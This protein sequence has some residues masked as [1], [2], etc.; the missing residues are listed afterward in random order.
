[1]MFKHFVKYLSSD[2]FCK[3]LGFI[4]LP[5][6]TSFLTP[7]EYGVYA[8]IISYVAIL[9]VLMPLN[10]HSSI[11]RFYYEPSINKN[12][13]LNT[14]ITLSL[15]IFFLFI[16]L[17]YLFGVFN[18]S[19]LIGINIQLYYKSILLVVFFKIIFD[20]YQQTLIPQQK[21]SEYTL[22]NIFRAYSTFIF[23]FLLL[24]F[25]DLSALS[26]IYGILICEIICFIYIVYKLVP[27]YN[28]KINKEAFH[29]IF[30]YSFFLLPYVLSLVAITQIDNIMIASF[31]TT[32]DVGIYN[33]AYVL[34][35]IPLIFFTQ[36]SKA[37]SPKYFS[38]MNEGKSY[39]LNFDVK[40]VLFLIALLVF[41][42]SLY[43]DII[44]L[45]LAGVKYKESINI[46]S[47]LC[48]SSFFAVSWQI[49]SRVF[50][51]EKNTKWIS[52]VGFTSLLINVILNYYFINIFGVIGA[53]YSTILTNIFMC[54]MSFVISKYV[55][56][57]FTFAI[58]LFAPS[59]LLILLILLINVFPNDV[60]IS[61][62]QIGF[63]FVFLLICFIN[64]TNIKSYFLI[65]F[66][67]T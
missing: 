24:K 61:Y 43:S 45:L 65:L 27:R 47:M 41:S 6:Y 1:M 2:F 28:F 3:V 63:P 54:T 35:V 11:S 58:N 51:Y 55:F 33:V 67:K 37:W 52:I 39:L 29:Y 31:L 66:G 57:Y 60:L 21:S 20:I 48:I 56:N 15:L 17:S 53:T 42:I 22:L 46:L 38:A 34:S 44:I 10:S 14:S 62:I 13:Y 49:L 36:F 50:L 19:S 26:L 4:S 12:V 32:A 40:F 59:L 16:I 64:R 8:L 30:N 25:Y 5:V 23:N 7:S 18:L 9:I